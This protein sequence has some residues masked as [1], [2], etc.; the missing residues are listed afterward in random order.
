MLHSFMVLTP[1]LLVFTHFN[2]ISHQRYNYRG[3]STQAMIA[4]VAQKV[5]LSHMRRPMGGLCYIFC[6]GA[7]DI[8]QCPIFSHI[9][10]QILRNKLKICYICTL[11]SIKDLDLFLNKSSSKDQDSN[12]NLIIA[13][14]LSYIENEATYLSK[15]S[16]PNSS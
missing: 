16:F 14:R 7:Q 2:K 4:Q 15:T 9:K 13:P 12:D 8:P 5:Y 6:T 1:T 3:C 10:L 11:S